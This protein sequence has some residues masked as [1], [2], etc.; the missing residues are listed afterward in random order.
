M[1]WGDR[2]VAARPRRASSARTPASTRCSSSTTTR[3]ASTA[4]WA[5]AGRPSRTASSTAPTRA[6]CRVLVAATLPELLDDAAAWRFAQAGVPAV[7]GLRTGLACAAAL[8]GA[9]RPTP[10]GCARSRREPTAARPARLAARSAS[11]ERGRWLAEH[12]AKALLRAAGIPV[13]DGRVVAGEDDAVAALAELG[14]P[15]AVKLSSPG[16]QHKTAAGALALDVAAEPDAARRPP[17]ARRPQRR[18]RGARRADGA[19]RRRADRRRPPR[20]R[21]ARARDRPRRHLRRG[22]RRRRRRPAPRDARARRGGARAASAAP[23]LLAGADLPAAA[24]LA[25][26]LAE[27]PGLELIECNPVLVHD[28]G[29]RRRRRRRQGDRAHERHRAAAGRGRPARARRR[30]SPPAD[31]DASSSAAATTASPA[32]PTSPAPASPCSCSSA[33][34][35]SAARA[36]SSA[37]SPTPTTSSAPAPTS[38]ACSTTLVI[39]ELGLKQRGLHVHIADP[40]L[41]VPFEDG[42]VLRPVGRRR[43]H[44]G[45]PR[46]AR[47]LQARTRTATGPTSTSSTRSAGGCA[48]A[49]ATAGS[50]TRPS[51]AEL[52][53]LLHGEQ[54]MIDVVFDASIAE[55]LDDH[56][57]DQRLKDALFGQ[58]VIG[59]WAGPK[60]KGTASDQ[61]HALPGR[62][63]GPRPAVGLR[64]RR[65]GDDLVRDRRRRAGGRRHARHRR[66]RRRD[67]ARRG[68]AGSRTGR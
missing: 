39:D 12:E 38:S 21:R 40:N 20:R 62:P 66:A 17:R 37:R 32:P 16:L 23:P 30:S 46:R 64:A 50:A 51:R 1:I 28:R 19:A 61:A 22:V 34:S 56:M 68:R 31:W 36:R 25:A 10:R 11:S 27:I 54:T 2:D 15:V 24:R 58:G 43:P 18:R 8:P 29:R 53:E 60:D 9:R 6:R 59:A 67:R 63:R 65:H 4:P 35:G 13:V 57:S 47:R 52:E 45:R 5:R 7:A 42:T 26:A 49:S 3:P 14:G 48:P 33:A 44:P 41:W 55:V